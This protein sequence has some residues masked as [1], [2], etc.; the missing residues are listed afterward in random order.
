M[1]KSFKVATV[2]TGTAAAAA[3]F[4]PA[5]GAATIRPATSHRNCALGVYTTST[6]LFW[7]TSKH[8]GP[9]CVGG[10]NGSSPTPLGN[11]YFT[12]A[13]AGNNAGFIDMTN[14]NTRSY[15]PGTGRIT[16]N[17]DVASVVIYSW[18][19]AGRHRCLT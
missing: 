2:F 5:A 12:Y 1:R 13:C 14:G 16:I 7:P 3:A 15:A 6:V 9:T 10:A 19:N 8:H 17:Q 11:N 18:S 4:A